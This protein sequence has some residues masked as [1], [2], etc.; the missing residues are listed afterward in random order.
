MP[1][2]ATSDTFNIITGDQLTR[3]AAALEAAIEQ[4]RAELD[5]ITKAA[6][7]ADTT[8]VQTGTDFAKHEVPGVGSYVIPAYPGWKALL[9][10]IQDREINV[11]FS[12][13]E[14]PVFDKIIGEHFNSPYMLDPLDDHYESYRSLRDNIAAVR[15]LL[16]QT[17]YSNTPAG[18]TPEKARI[19]L[20]EIAEFVGEGLNN[21][22]LYMGVL[23]NHKWGRPHIDLSRARAKGGEGAQYIYEEILKHQRH[24][25]WMRP[26]DAVLSLFGGKSAPDWML[27][28]ASETGFISGLF[29][30]FSTSKLPNSISSTPTSAEIEAALARVGALEA[31][32]AALRG[33]MELNTMSVDLDAIGNH[34]L[35]SAEHMN[36]VETL[37]EPVRQ[38][39]IEIAREI[40]RKLKFALG[41]LNI[42]D[43]LKLKPTDDMAT[44]GAI[45]GVSMV[46]ERLLAWARGL[47]P[48]IMEHPS[49]IAATRAVGQ[50][51]YLA[52]LEAFRMARAAGNTVQAENL[53]EQL[54]R[55]PSVYATATDATFGGLLSKVENGINAVLNRAQNISGPGVGVS[56]TRSNEL[57]NIAAAP[58][59][60][61]ALQQGAEAA[62]ATSAANTKQAANALAAQTASEMAMASQI[63]SQQAARAAQQP[64]GSQ[65]PAQP[66]VTPGTA[67][68]IA[69]TGRV[70]RPATTTP[71]PTTAVSPTNTA[72]IQQAQRNAAN[73]AARHQV[74]EAERQHHAQ[75]EQQ[76]IT[77]MNAQREADQRA[78]ARKAAAI[79]AA[80]RRNPPTAN[81]GPFAPKQPLQPKTMTVAPVAITPPTKPMPVQGLKI[82]PKI[83]MD[84]QKATN[85]GG[86]TTPAVETG[87][88]SAATIAA[89]Q[90]IASAVA[91]SDTATLPP[92]LRN[93][94]QYGR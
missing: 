18:M 56:H 10:L 32:R 77:Q 51:G 39:A 75:E 86:L 4:A 31:E 33:R 55:I 19:A 59:A 25:N 29:S 74:E 83:L 16:M 26:F 35:F 81:A 53:G 57:G 12:L 70:V 54:K 64:Q 38:D 79:Q 65:T 76:R 21:N 15:N 80:A 92:N 34:L 13:K 40:L 24:S 60:G 3:E 58:T 89:E 41:D 8:A 1:L 61:F 44:L 71:S 23:P 52:K 45:K 85:A 47:D 5:A 73:M 11:D 94:P 72:Q 2:D 66:R 93:N 14:Y 22:Y 20:A 50:F 43:G 90:Q 36:R 30:L 7:I 63:Q 9:K 78:A 62:R 88:K 82:D 42:L 68:Q 91:K 67:R 84:I 27:P 46:Y 87:R 69:T 48:S 28:P 17:Y 49:I 37:S 6:S